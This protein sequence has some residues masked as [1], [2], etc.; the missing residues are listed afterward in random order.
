MKALV[1]AGQSRALV[2][3]ADT[4]VPAVQAATLADLYERRIRGNAVLT[5][6]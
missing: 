3:L 5:I 4:G 6:P 1:P 2:A